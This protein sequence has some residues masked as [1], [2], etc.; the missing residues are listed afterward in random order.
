[1]ILIGTGSELALAREAADLLRAEGLA[2]RVVSMPC[3][4]RFDAQPRDYR[5]QVLPP[6]LR[7][8]VAVEAGV[9]DYWRKYVGLDGEVVGIDRFGASAPAEQLY[10][11]FDITA[12][13]VAAAA[14]RSLTA[15]K[16]S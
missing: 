16:A 10:Q 1:M 2:V 9:R 11:H 7:A 12:Q 5:D 14:R 8:R 15:L 6:Q 3:T 13:A 4:R